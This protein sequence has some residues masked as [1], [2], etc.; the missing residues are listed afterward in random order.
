MKPSRVWRIG[1]GIGERTVQV[2]PRY[3]FYGNAL[4]IAASY[5]VLAEQQLPA[6]GSRPPS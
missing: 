4:P 2:H 6:S 3:D 5:R 1:T